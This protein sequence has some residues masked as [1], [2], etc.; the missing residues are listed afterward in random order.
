MI[1]VLIPRRAI[2]LLD[3]ERFDRPILLRIV[4]NRPIRAE[5][6]H[7]GT[8]DDALLQPFALIQVCL[9]DQLEGIDVGLE[10]LRQEVVIVVTD[11]IQQPE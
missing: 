3:L 5:L 8:S 6:A 2:G 11:G 9:I 4:Q 1:A 10:V 7:L